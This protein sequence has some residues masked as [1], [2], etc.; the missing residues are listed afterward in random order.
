MMKIILISIIGG[1]PNQ[2]VPLAVSPSAHG[3]DTV[4]KAGGVNVCIVVYEI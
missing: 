4:Q 1:V 3:G 2:S